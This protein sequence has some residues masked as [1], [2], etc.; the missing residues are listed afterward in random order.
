[1]GVNKN[2]PTR[3][4]DGVVQNPIGIGWNKADVAE[5]E[6]HLPGPI[7]IGQRLKRLV[8]DRSPASEVPGLRE[9]IIDFI[10]RAL[11]G[12]ADNVG[13]P[14]DLPSPRWHG[15][16]TTKPACAGLAN[17]FNEALG[18]ALT[19]LEALIHL[20][21]DVHPAATADELVRAV[22]SHQ[23]LQRVA[24]LH[25]YILRSNKRGA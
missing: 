11:D 7:T 3:L 16:K 4:E 21:D 24:D 23:R 14:H 25:R 1:M 2:L 6:G 22:A 20:V 9:V 13:T 18:L 19:G 5:A 12:N 15:E 10:E 8:F 17:D